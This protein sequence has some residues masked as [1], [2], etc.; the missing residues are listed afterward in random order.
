M[1]RALL[2]ELILVGLAGA[3]QAQSFPSKAA[4]IVV[5][6]PPGGATDIMARIYADITKIAQNPEVRQ[7]VSGMGADPVVQSPQ[8]LAA[9]L[10]SKT[11]KWEKVVREA[12][13]K[14]D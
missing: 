14:A 3:V 2:G 10:R 4:R 11:A 12:G 6:F 7:K 5:A 13:I 9:L 1:Q 8:D